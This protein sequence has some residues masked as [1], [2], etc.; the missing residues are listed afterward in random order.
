M[1]P[2]T[3]SVSPLSELFLEMSDLTLGRRNAI[4]FRSGRLVIASLNALE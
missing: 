2:G 3:A 4:S 1:E